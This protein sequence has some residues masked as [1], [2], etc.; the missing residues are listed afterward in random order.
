MKAWPNDSKEIAKEVLQRVDDMAAQRD[1]WNGLYEDVANYVGPWFKGFTGKPAHPYKPDDRMLDSTARRAARI[2]AA[3]MLSGAS[4][5]SQRWFG[6]TLANREYA[7]AL[8]PAGRSWLEHVEDDAYSS[9]FLYG[10]YP[11]QFVCYGQAGAF[12]WQCMFVDE[13]LE[14]Y[15]GLRFRA[16]P[17][18]EL[19]IQD[20]AMGEPDTVGRRF[21]RTPR[22]AAQLWGADN[23]PEKVKKALDD[24]NSS[25]MEFIHFVLPDEETRGFRRARRMRYRSFYAS[26]IDEQ[27]ITEGGYFEQP[28][29]VTRS[30]RLPGTPYSYSPGTEALGDARMINEMKRLILEAGQLNVAPPYL[31]PDD[32]FVGRFSFE[33]RAMNYYRRD[34]NT[35]ANDFG[36]L[37][38]GGDPR[39]GWDLLQSTKGDINE[40]FYVDLFMAI[41]ERIKAGAVPTAHEVAELAGER[42][43]LLG[44]MLVNQQRENFRHLFDR[45]FSLRMESGA[46]PPPPAE[47]VNQ[48]LDVEYTSSLFL[49]QKQQQTKAIMQTY[50][51]AAGMAELGAPEVL[52]I[53]DHDANMRRIMDQRG[54]PQSGVRS[55]GAV[56]ELRSA[57]SEANAK[58]EREAKVLEIA[59]AY[60]GLARGAEPG[61]P[62]KALAGGEGE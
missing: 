58:A 29:I 36:P 53:F 1:P 12:G 60:P 7:K 19:Y 43:F 40:A 5:P 30:Y 38:V 6:L 8:S 46:L 22:Q 49:A 35:T 33:P 34:G 41:R 10:Y 44:P 4:S 13:P 50:S 26:V 52:D 21:M 16:I 11:E 37:G 45:V 55:E 31:V 9:L 61:S 32:G 56:Q 18:P 24:K 14:H 59:K 17:L 2:F 57:R 42:M 48:E 25:E 20:N 23:L 39:F 47:L 28:Y 51:D 62:A 3:G 15:Q 27:V 54:F